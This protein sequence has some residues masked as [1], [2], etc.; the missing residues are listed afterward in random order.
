MPDALLGEMQAAAGNDSETETSL[1]IAA[2]IVRDVRPLCAGVHLM[3][4]GWE[5]HIPR[6]LR[7]GGV[8]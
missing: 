1:A 8:R 4:L 2:R 7:A 3:T 6:I 5:E